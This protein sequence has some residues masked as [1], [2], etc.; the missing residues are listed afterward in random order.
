MKYLIKN[1]IKNK[2]KIRQSLLILVSLNQQKIRSSY[3][4]INII[5][6]CNNT[7]LTM[8]YFPSFCYPLYTSTFLLLRDPA[9]GTISVNARD[10]KRIEAVGFFRCLLL[11]RDSTTT[12]YPFA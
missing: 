8:Y 6:S 11:S 12:Q 2:S 5:S 3:A 1:I 10:K 7:S 9:L 4:H